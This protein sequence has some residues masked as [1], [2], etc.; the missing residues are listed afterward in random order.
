V[1]FATLID[2]VQRLSFEEKEELQNLVTMY[3]IQER[4]EHF[5]ETYLESQKEESNNTLEFSSN[6]NRLR[7][8]LE[9]K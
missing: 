3:L 2:E 5:Y 1:S 4:R 6:I 9:D 7:E 8:M